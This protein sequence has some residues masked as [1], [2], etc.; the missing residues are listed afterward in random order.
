MA[1]SVSI[2]QRKNTAQKAQDRCLVT[3]IKVAKILDEIYDLRSR[4]EVGEG[5]GGEALELGDSKAWA[6][7]V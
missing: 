5:R 6:L 7:I 4:K 3:C 1:G 2:K